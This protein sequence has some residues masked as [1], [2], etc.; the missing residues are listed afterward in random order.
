MSN[1]SARAPATAPLDALAAVAGSV[2]SEFVDALL[3][4]SAYV[5]SA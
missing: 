5:Q 3:L 1:A 2:S 4:Q